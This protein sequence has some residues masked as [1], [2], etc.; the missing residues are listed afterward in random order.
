[1]IRAWRGWLVVFGAGILVGSRVGFAA[2]AVLGSQE[3]QGVNKWL[4]QGADGGARAGGARSLNATPVVGGG[5][6]NAAPILE[7]GRYRDTILPAEYLYY[8]VRVRRRASAPGMSTVD[9]RALATPIWGDLGVQFNRGPIP[10]RRTCAL[11]ELGTS[12]GRPLWILSNPEG[13]RRSRCTL[14][15]RRRRPRTLRR[16]AGRV[17]R[18]RRLLHAFNATTCEAR[19]RRAPRSRSRFY[20]RAAGISEQPVG[21][22][23][24]RRPTDH[25]EA[26]SGGAGA[27]GGATEPGSEAAASPP[28]FGVGGLSGSGV[29]CGIVL[30]QRRSLR[31][32]SARRRTDVH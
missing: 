1:M 10:L 12:E 8:G 27:R 6:F 26:P 23:R 22:G 3:H 2:A 17:A 9:D 16:P 18:P 7:P 30:R 15:N 5:S 21:D 19:I 13:A 24:R 11:R 29:I 31:T 28:W 32:G 4:A 14:R 20:G 25:S